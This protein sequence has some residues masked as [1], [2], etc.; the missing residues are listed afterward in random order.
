M[1][2]RNECD[3]A[4]VRAGWRLN[5]TRPSSLAGCTPLYH[6]M[7]VQPSMPARITP[8]PTKSPHPFQHGRETGCSAD[9]LITQACPQSKT[10]FDKGLPCSWPSSASATSL[11]LSVSVLRVKVNRFASHC[12]DVVGE[13]QWTNRIKQ[14]DFH[15]AAAIYLIP[16][17]TSP[18]IKGR[19]V[20]KN[21]C[22]EANAGR[23]PTAVWRVEGNLPTSSHNVETCMGRSKLP[24]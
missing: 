23:K 2:V 4:T 5:R 7:I 10:G 9:T 12:L 19:L 8:Q 6:E 16:A 13:G 14:Q 17:I 18:F 1:G 21:I 11:A 24:I 3:A 15:P 20:S 22:G